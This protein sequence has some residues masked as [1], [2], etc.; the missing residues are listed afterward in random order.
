MVRTILIL[1]TILIIGCSKD[2]LN[3]RSGNDCKECMYFINYKG[4]QAWASIDDIRTEVYGGV[5]SGD[6]CTY[7][8]T[9]QRLS[10][11]VFMLEKKCK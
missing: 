8:D 3:L 6:L 7:L 1:L 5:Y 2:D 10:V 11:D 9:V 4:I